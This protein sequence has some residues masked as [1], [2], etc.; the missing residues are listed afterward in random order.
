MSRFQRTMA[1]WRAIRMVRG[2]HWLLFLSLAIPL[3]ISVCYTIAGFWGADGTQILVG[4][5][6]MA[7][8]FVVGFAV[9]P[10]W[11]QRRR[12]LRSLIAILFASL[13]FWPTLLQWGEDEEGNSVQ[14]NRF[15]TEVWRADGDGIWV[16]LDTTPEIINRYP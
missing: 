8:L 12:F 13:V 5:Q 7:F 3:L 16:P 1:A 2:T 11:N 6:Q 10:F 4:M 14:I 15:T 9:L